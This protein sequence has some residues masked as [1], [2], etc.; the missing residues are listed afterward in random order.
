VTANELDTETFNQ[1]ADLALEVEDYALEG[2]SRP[3]S[4]DFT[5]RTTVI[6]LRGAGHEGQGEDVTYSGSDQEV[7][8]GASAT[9]PLAGSYTLREFSRRLDELELFPTPPES[10]AFGDYRRWAFESAALDL[11]LRQAELGLAEAV[12]RLPRPVTYVVSLRLGEP[13]SLDRLLAWL[14]LYPGLRFKLDATSSWDDGLVARLVAT[15]S[16]DSIDF[17][18]AYRGTVVDQ[19]PDPALYERVAAAFPDAWLEDPALTPETQAVL[20]RYRARVTWDAVIHSVADI[21]AL[22]WEPRMLNIKP[23]RFG[24]IERLFA[25]YDFCDGRSIRMYGGGQFELGPGRG[26]IQRLASL[27]HPDAPNDVAPGEFNA[28]TPVPGLPESPLPPAGADPG[29]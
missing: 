4:S 16:V 17:K 20:D 29:L 6:R 12:N 21:E 13:P 19:P 25:A 15:G 9:L 14:E 27:F 18:G 11:A 23:S 1:V 28:T 22:P 5:R 10:A 3:V 8:Q 26:Q 2:L 24:T 7:F